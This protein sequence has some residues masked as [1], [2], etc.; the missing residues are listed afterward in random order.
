MRAAKRVASRVSEVAASRKSERS[1]SRPCKRTSV[2]PR[3]VGV[4]KDRGNSHRS[5][6]GEPREVSTRIAVQARAERL[7]WQQ[8]RATVHIVSSSMYIRDVPTLI[9]FRGEWQTTAPVRSVR[10]LPAA[11]QKIRGAAD[12]THILLA[13]AEGQFVH[14]IHDEHMIAVE[15]V[16]S[17]RNFRIHGEVTAI[18]IVSAGIS[19]MREE[20][21]AMA[22]AL[23]NL[24]LQR[25]VVGAGI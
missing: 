22:K 20:L 13:F 23:L 4:R 15:I 25:V 5:N 10:N 14:R 19:V 12:V 2:L 8:I 11:D 1:G 3:Q 21:Q 16:E 7:P 9:Y 18:V 17:I 6:R 24:H